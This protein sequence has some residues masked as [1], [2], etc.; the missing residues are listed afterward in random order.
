[1][2]T[3]SRE[4]LLTPAHATV[5]EAAGVMAYAISEIEKHSYDEYKAA[6]NNLVAAVAILRKQ[7]AQP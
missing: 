7:E 3:I 2:R 1:M 5:I 4:T 6:S